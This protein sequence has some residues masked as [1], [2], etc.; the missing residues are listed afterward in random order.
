MSG[1]YY[2]LSDD[3]E[4]YRIANDLVK[5]RALKQRLNGLTRTLTGVWRGMTD[6]FKQESYSEAFRNQP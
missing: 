1:K 2:A 4:V 6:L 3:N 5:Q